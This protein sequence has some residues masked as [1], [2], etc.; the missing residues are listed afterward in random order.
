V[1]TIDLARGPIEYEL[2]DGATPALVFLHDGLGT[3]RS[4]RGF[5]RELCDATGRAALL[6]TRYGYGESAAIEGARKPRFMHEEALEVLPELLDRLAIV[7]PVLVGHSDG[8][9]I[10][11]IHAGTGDRPVAGLVVIAPH[12]F[13]EDV[14]VA[15]IAEAV[16]EFETSDLR[17]KLARH[18]ADAAATFRGWSD[19]WLS[20][21]FRDWNIEDAVA[22]VVC[23]VLVIQ[24][25]DDRYGT[26]AQVE[27][28]ARGT[29]GSVETL[30]LPDCGHAPHLERSR[31]TLDAA[32]RFVNGLTSG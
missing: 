3:L 31:E 23:P 21:D 27:A 32:T 25:T 20:D 24:G 15:G 13:V 11:I 2:I 6:S 4:M 22:G 5:A 8:A 12:V 7:D 10:A 26:L 1:P 19:V 17:A 14:T 29:G 18:H 16:R 28:I 9:S 30:V